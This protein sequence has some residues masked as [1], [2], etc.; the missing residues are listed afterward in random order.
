MFHLQSIELLHWDYCQRLSLPL[1]GAIITVAGPNGSGKTTLLD[2][3]R[4]LLGLECSGGRSFKTYARHANADASWLRAVVDNRPRTRQSS[5]RPFARNLLYA[6]QVTLACRIQRNSGDWQRRYYM[7]DGDVAIEQLLEL[8]DKDWLGIEHWRR[9]LETAGLSR[10]IA[11]VLALEQGQTDRLCEYSPKELLR[12]VFDVFGDQEVLDRYEEARRHQRDVADEAEAAAKELAHGQAQL[13]LVEARL[14]LYRQYQAKLRERERL[15]TE[16]IPVLE[17]RDA[18]DAML[19]E[20]QDLHRQRLEHGKSLA[21]QRQDRQALLQLAQQQEQLA[22][23]LAQAE[24]QRKAAQEALSEARGHETPVEDLV[25]QADELHALAQVEGDAE[26]LALRVQ[27]LQQQCQAHERDWH[28]RQQE[29]EAAQRA[30]EQLRSA[31]TA[32]CPEDATRFAQLL[33]QQGIAHHFVADAIEIIDEQWRAAAEGVLRSARWVVVLE[34]PADEAR[35]SQLAEQQRYRHYLVADAAPAPE[36]VP[37]HSLLAALHVAAPLPVWLLRTL[38]AIRCVPDTAAGFA[39]GGE[40]ITPQAYWRDARGGRSVWVP[41]SQ[42]QFGAAA[43]AARRESIEQRLAELDA[44][45]QAIAQQQRESERQLQAAKAAAAGHRAAEELARRSEEFATARS[46]LAQLRQA[47]ISAGQRYAELDQQHQRLGEQL[48]QA[49][50]QYQQTQQRLQG[51][52]SAASR[53]A[54]EWQGRRDALRTRSAQSRR[55]RGQFPPR[56]IAPEAIAQLREQFTNATQAR[57]RGQAV[58]RELEEGEWETDPSIEE[59]HTLMVAQVAGQQAQLQQRQASNES[60]RIAVD[61]A[62]ERYID[63]LRATVRRYRKNITELGE[64]AGVAVQADSPHLENDDAALRQAE[65]RVHFNFDG[66]GQIGLNDGEASGGQ[67]VIKSLILLV[68][69][70]KDDEA[71]GGF[72]FID[73]PFAHLDVRN[74]Q[75]VGHFLKS[76]RAQ[77]V[78]T[79]PITHNV[80]VFEPADVTLVTAKKKPG[81]RWAPPIGVLQRRVAPEQY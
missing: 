11:R 57:L 45:L 31:R 24:T 34:N 44:Q 17:W 73:E 77:Y 48:R 42:H 30:L 37:P 8:P 72:V 2:A 10:A 49:Q 3:M 20:A 18:R 71:S 13:A 79:T 56:W 25:R 26:Q 55:Q 5:S 80:E 54:R 78:L 43:L 58:A 61:N 19:A 62:R 52:E 7:A 21:R 68:G 81:E 70:L 63:V 36:R 28:T 41:P 46:Q 60:A 12:L 9:R 75:L 40:W 69:L 66:K 35:A 22:V 74:I 33:R 53:F 51:D 4:T 23:Q 29:R 27:Q 6:D 14:N 50:S 32:P 76:T 47:R 38:A 15:H 16:V 65:L 59:R 1:D 64:L 67:Q 39:A